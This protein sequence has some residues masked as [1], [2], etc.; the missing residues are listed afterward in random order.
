MSKAE[1][2]N[3]TNTLTKSRETLQHM[4]GLPPQLKR[5]LRSLFKQAA[6]ENLPQATV[7][8]RLLELYERAVKVKTINDNPASLQEAIDVDL[9]GS[10]INELQHLIAELDFEGECGEQLLS[11]RN[12][13]LLGV[14]PKR[15]LELS[16]DSIR[17]VVYGTQQERKQSQKFLEQLNQGL[18]KLRDHTSKNANEGE[19]TAKDRQLIANDL[20]EINHSIHTLANSSSP[21]A[22]KAQVQLIGERMHALI[23]RNRTL[24]A[25]EQA[26]IERLHSNTHTLSN[27]FD[28][29]DSY[30]RRLNDQQHRLFLD[31]LTK[32]YNRAA[33]QERLEQEYRRWLRYQQPLCVAMID[34]DHFKEINDTYG[35]LAGD[36]ALKVIARTMHKALSD[37]DF[38]A[39]FGGEEFVVILSDSDEK[40]RQ[41][42]LTNLRDAVS[43][44]PFK[45]RDHK[46]SITVSVGATLFQES[47][48]PTSVL[49]RTDQA[50]YLAKE[51]GRNRL[52]W[53]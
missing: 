39:R 40:T 10:L 7:A 30:C 14:S 29:T 20:V 25:R 34:I 18:D 43:H 3:L 33:L 27:L 17:L 2:H 15:L 26:L 11:I 38:I 9:Q 24:E 32:V 31:H 5:D 46:V 19:R 37:T 47:D 51:Q 21:A 42:I 52:I 8:T 48:T 6:N 49:E 36:K 12:E 53:S 16:L 41:S 4:R 22:L 23:E 45:F 44:I 50:L 35:H 13:L 28:Q 1:L